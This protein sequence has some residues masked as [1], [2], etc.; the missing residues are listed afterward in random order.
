MVRLIIIPTIF[1]FLALLMSSCNPG[2]P[3]Q[4][5]VLGKLIGR[6]CTDTFTLTLGEDGMYRCIKYSPA[7]LGKVPVP[8]SCKGTYALEQK[9]GQWILNYE[10]DPNPRGINHCVFSFPVWN[11]EKG[12]LIGESTATTVKE[13][14][15]GNELTQGGC[16]E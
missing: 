8:E 6:Y 5:E 3:A 16:D 10:R 9:E 1:C 12:Y 13:P 4:E 14:F 7:I 15:E 11:Q 2:P